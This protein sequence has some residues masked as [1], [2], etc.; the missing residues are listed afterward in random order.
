MHLLPE[1]YIV[2]QEIYLDLLTSRAQK[3][4]KKTIMLVKKRNRMNRIKRQII[5]YKTRLK[6]AKKLLNTQFCKKFNIV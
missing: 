3:I 5:D 1:D 6:D 4:Y 2:P